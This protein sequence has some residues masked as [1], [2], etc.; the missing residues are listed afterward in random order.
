MLFVGGVALNSFAIHVYF[1]DHIMNS[2]H[3]MVKFDSL[4]KT[5]CSSLLSG[6]QFVIC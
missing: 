1:S 5:Q 4:P 2:V 6:W 3:F